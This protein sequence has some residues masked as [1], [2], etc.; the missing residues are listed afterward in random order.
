MVAQL[1]NWV[2]FGAGTALTF[3]SNGRGGVSAVIVTSTAGTTTYTATTVTDSAPWSMA[4]VAVGD[5][6]FNTEGYYGTVRGITGVVVTVDAWRRLGIRSGGIPTNGTACSI[7]APSHLG[8]Y[9][10]VAIDH[11]NIALTTGTAT[12]SITDC[13]GTVYTGMVFATTSGHA[14]TFN[15]GPPGLQV[16]G[17]FG[18][19]CSATTIA[20]VISYRPLE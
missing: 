7:F 12:V 4:G 1:S 13:K 19:I 20:G 18:V 6:I 17:P 11:I 16:N 3:P 10:S 8:V 9:T 15:F 2:S 14:K 5:Y